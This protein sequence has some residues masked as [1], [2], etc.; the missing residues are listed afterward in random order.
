MKMHVITSY[1]IHYT[2]LYDAAFGN[3]TMESPA[4]N[5]WCGW[6]MVGV[7]ETGSQSIQVYPNPATDQLTVKTSQDIRRIELVNYLGQVV[8]NQEVEGVITSYSIHYTK[9]YDWLKF[10]MI[11]LSILRILMFTDLQYQIV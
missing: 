1:S 2:K 4:S 6:M 3:S 7:G 5:E 11:I 9:L 8:R 10:V